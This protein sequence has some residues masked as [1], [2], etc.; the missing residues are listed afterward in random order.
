LYQADIYESAFQEAAATRD[1]SQEQE[2]Q[3]ALD[4]LVVEDLVTA[5]ED[6]G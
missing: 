5:A 6:G 1:A 3:K 4:A 2:R